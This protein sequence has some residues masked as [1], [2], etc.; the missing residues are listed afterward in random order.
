MTPLCRA[1][2]AEGSGRM[3]E[4]DA[5][6]ATRVMEGLSD[7]TFGQPAGC[8]RTRRALPAAPDRCRSVATTET[9]SQFQFSEDKPDQLGRS[10]A[11]SVTIY[12]TRQDIWTFREGP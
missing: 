3:S 11:N 4:P 1:R 5:S 10:R 8:C 2:H 7:P 9:E 6:C 12:L